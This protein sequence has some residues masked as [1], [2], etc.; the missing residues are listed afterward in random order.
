MKRRTHFIAFVVAAAVVFVLAPGCVSTPQSRIQKNPDL[1]NSFPPEVQEN[2]KQGRIAVGYT[3]DMVLIALG[4]PARVLMRMTEAGQTE[5]WVY[6][7]TRYVA[8]YRSRPAAFWYR[9]SRGRLRQGV[10]WAWMDAGGQQEY[11]TLRVEFDGD[12]VK[13]IESLR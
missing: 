12:K 13:A 3:R 2:V 11:E 6:S 4:A 9:D 7:N 10:D 5:V 1:F 8:D